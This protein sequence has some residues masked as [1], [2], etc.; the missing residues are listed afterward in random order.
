MY[1][2]LSHR[3]PRDTPGIS[4]LTTGVDSFSATGQS[5]SFIG[6]GAGVDAAITAGSTTINAGDRVS[7]SVA[8]GTLDLTLANSGGALATSTFGLGFRATN[9]PNVTV[10]SFGGGDFGSTLDLGSFDATSATSLSNIGS[11]GVLTFN[12]ANNLATLNITRVTAAT[13]L[14]FVNTLV[15]TGNTTVAAVVNVDGASNAGNAVGVTLRGVALGT[16]GAAVVTVNALGAQSNIALNSGGDTLRTLTVNSAAAN[17][18]NAVV[19]GNGT[20]TLNFTGAGTS[21]VDISGSTQATTVVGVAGNDT[22]VFADANL[23]VA[24]SIALGA[25]TNNLGISIAAAANGAAITSAAG[26]N[27]ATGVSSLLLVGQ[28]TTVGNP[29]TTFFNA[30]NFSAVNPTRVVLE[31]FVANTGVQDYATTAGAAGFAAFTATNVTTAKTLAISGDISARPATAG[32]AGGAGGGNGVAGA[33]G[34]LAVSVASSTPLQTLNL[35]I[36]AGSRDLGG[37]AIIGGAGSVGSVGGNGF[38]GNAGGVGGA[39]AAGLAAITA[40]TNINTINLTSSASSSSITNTIIGG[41]AGAGGNGGDGIALAGNDG[42]AGGAGANAAVA[43]LNNGAETFNISGA[44]RLTI[45]GGAAAAAG[46]AGN[47]AGAGGNGGAGGAAGLRA[48]GFAAQVNIQGATATG[49]LSIQGSG[50][51]M[52]DGG[53]AITANTVLAVGDVIVTGSGADTIVGG[54]GG[55]IITTGTGADRIAYITGNAGEIASGDA[56]PTAVE[57]GLL[58]DTNLI[59]RITDFTT[60]TDKI[61]INTGLAFSSAADVTFTAATVTNVGTFTGI[62]G[63]AITNI[64]GLVAAFNTAVTGGAVASAA[65]T[66][67]AYVFTTGSITG[68]LANASNQTFLVLN[69]TTAA[70]QSADFLI[71]I[72]G[73]TGTFS[74]SN[75]NYAAV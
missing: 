52:T 13:T 27:A 63:N 26:I 17:T 33:V 7:S 6:V 69:N 47:A 31:G 66:A 71:N 74:G 9:I 29:G 40:F 44:A 62:T 20:R 53:V 55:D 11:Q 10:G 45:A 28:G 54:G 1:Q 46:T 23:N 56:T 12:N 19:D 68:G 16:D 41:A 25:G 3:L 2:K 30:V 8:N 72:T 50:A 60:A 35:V 22:V 39:G 34:A 36:S 70:I 37:V 5:A 18:V 58:A 65:G 75:F 24:D 51:L 4:A 61:T 15:P 32:T 73:M 43:I 64:N 57:F 67:Q 42:G 59:D 14:Q 38:G 49:N 48:L 21:L